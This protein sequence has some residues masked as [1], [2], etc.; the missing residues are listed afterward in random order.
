MPDTARPSRRAVLTAAT[1][2]AGF[3]TF[4]ALVERTLAG[5]P[6]ILKPLPPQWF[7]DYGSNAE[8]RWDSVDPRRY[9]T[10]PERQFVRHHTATPRIDPAT[11]QLEIFGDGLGV[12]RT[13]DQAVTLSYADL[14]RLSATRMTTV[15]ECAG[16]GRSFFATQQ[17]H[18][19]TGTQW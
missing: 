9:L 19:A 7:V 13:R 15:H 8:M 2:G 1:A 12:P 16:N 17:G 14:R 10:T 5:V 3:L 18:A 6:A 11:Y 4:P